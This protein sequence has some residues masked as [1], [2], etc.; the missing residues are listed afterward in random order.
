MNVSQLIALTSQ[1]L[2][3]CFCCKCGP[4]AQ[5]PD[6]VVQWCPERRGG[7][8]RWTGLCWAGRQLREEGS[9]WP[10]PCSAGNV[11]LGSRVW[12][13]GSW[14]SGRQ[15]PWRMLAHDRVSISR[16]RWQVVRRDVVSSSCV[17][18]GAFASSKLSVSFFHLGLISFFP[19]TFYSVSSSNEVDDWSLHMVI[20]GAPRPSVSTQSKVAVQS[21]PSWSPPLVLPITLSIQK[22][23]GGALCLFI[24][25]LS[26]APR[27]PHSGM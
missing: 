26:L 15:G 21:V 11:L 4:E 13:L 7:I 3:S 6:C 16:T 9:G 2:V 5:V 25:L 20:S 18:N 17:K 10:S 27:P 23:A 1:R 22:G 12:A 19:R 14:A 24:Y 8:T